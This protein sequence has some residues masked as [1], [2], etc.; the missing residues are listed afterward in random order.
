MKLR[1]KVSRLEMDGKVTVDL[2]RF[3]YFL[4]VVPTIYVADDFGRKIIETNQYAVTQQSHPSTHG[5]GGNTVPGILSFLCSTNVLGIFFKYDVEPLQLT[6]MHGHISTYRFLMR[7]IALVGGVMICTEWGYKGYDAV[8]QQL[9]KRN[10]RSSSADG[11]L[12]GT[13]EKEG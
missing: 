7:L 11:L 12:N 4:S 10:R 9:D 2:Y 5:A 8:T 1:M 13:L 3:Q 6:I